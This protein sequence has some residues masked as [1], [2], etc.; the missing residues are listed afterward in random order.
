MA[1]VKDV[2]KL[3]GVSIA[4]VSRVLNNSAVVSSETRD[5]VLQAVKKLD[6]RPNLI[7]SSLRSK[8]SKTIG[9][10]V[11]G[12]THVTF[13]MNTSYIADACNDNGYSLLIGL[14]HDDPNLE[15]SLLDS[16]YRR[17][18]DGI[19]ISTPSAEDFILKQIERFR[20]PIVLI[21]R[22]FK[23]NLCNCVSI[24]NYKAGYAAGAYLVSLGH[25]KIGCLTRP[26]TIW[27]CYERITGFKQAL[28]DHGVE[29]MDRYILEIPSFSVEAGAQGAQAF[30]SMPPEDR[31]TA[32]W[33]VEDHIA[34]GV[35]R[36]FISVGI[37]VPEEVSIMG[38]DNLDVGSMLSP[39]LTTITYPFKD[40]SDVAV[41]CIVD[42]C[43][44][45][46]SGTRHYIYEPHIVERESTAAAP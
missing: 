16:F 20:I 28:R 29:V 24:D 9:L 31:P 10:I 44:G 21:D 37:R 7:A 23:S 41:Q 5:A 30:L 36:S 33:A 34:A 8:D 13:G 12:R 43:K 6:Y 1:S 40:I 46:D 4:T 14:H 15:Q 39:S 35:M 27:Q 25:K 18:I 42:H 19:I 26:V 32:I 38:M 11:P 2:A 3:A 45:R 17:N 22:I